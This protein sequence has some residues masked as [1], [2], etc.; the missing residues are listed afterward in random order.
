MNDLGRV[1]AATADH[2][3]RMPGV[4]TYVD[5]LPVIDT[6]I[7]PARCGTDA[8]DSFGPFSVRH[9]TVSLVDR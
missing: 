6:D 7:D 8:T 1:A 4:F 5:E 9:E 2:P 3:E